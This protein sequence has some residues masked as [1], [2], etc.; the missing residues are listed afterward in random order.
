VLGILLEA[1]LIFLY[2]R[3]AG[4][5]TNGTLSLTSILQMIIVLAFVLAARG[6]NK[7]AKLL[8]DSDRLR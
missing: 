2:Y 1:I 5:F 7:D 4:T 6:I 8:K 3:E